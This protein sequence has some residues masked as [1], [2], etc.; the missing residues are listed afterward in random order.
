MVDVDGV[1]IGDGNFV[2]MAGPCSVEGLEQIRKTAQ[3]AKAGSAKILRGGLLNREH[4]LM[5]FKG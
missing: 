5:L 4:R 3:M 2:T 1:K